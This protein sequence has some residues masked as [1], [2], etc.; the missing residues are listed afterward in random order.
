M[1]DTLTS[2]QAYQFALDPTPTQERALRSHCGAARFAY[3][4]LIKRWLAAA[5]QYFAETTY[6]I[7]KEERTPLPFWNFQGARN[8]MN[9]LKT[10]IAPWWEQNSKEAFASGARDAAEGAMNWYK[11]LTGKRKGPRMGRPRLKKRTGTLSMRFTTGVMRI[12]KGRNAVVLPRLGEI[13]TH[14]SPRKLRRRIQNG[15]ARIMSAT[16]KRKAGRWFV[17][18]TTKVTRPVRT[19]LHPGSTVGVDVGVKDLLVAATPDG[20]E[21]LRVPMPARIRTLEK[22]RRALQRRTRHQQ[23]PRRRVAPSKR[24]QRSHE[25]QARLYGK[26]MNL[27]EDAIHKGTT[28]LSKRY[29]TVVLETLNVAGMRSRGGAYKKGLN[30]A[31][32]RAALATTRRLLEYKTTRESGSLVL[33]DRWY[34]SSKTC[35]ACGVVR[36]KLHLSEREYVCDSCGVV[37]DRDLNAAINLARLA[38]ASPGVARLVDVEPSGRPEHLRD[39]VATGYEASTF[40]KPSS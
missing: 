3:N 30:G 35:S 17:I 9:A 22:K 12:A 33:A 39:V 40:N 38:G 23:A 11:S 8:L 16:V 18:F 21:V 34:P 5:N 19:H 10:E 36:T 20:E 4:E 14:E 7:P 27:R 31:I 25:R 6:G 28:R 26:I 15:T 24:W 2:I 32:S 13:H 1:S 37:L 29:E